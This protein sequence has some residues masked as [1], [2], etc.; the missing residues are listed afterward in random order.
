MTQQLHELLPVV[1]QNTCMSLSHN[2]GVTVFCVFAPV[3]VTG[4]LSWASS[5]VAPSY[6]LLMAALLRIVALL[7]VSRKLGFLSM[8]A[9]CLLPYL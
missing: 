2:I 5:P 6:P 4:L 7:S 1:G 9:S 3:I 8:V